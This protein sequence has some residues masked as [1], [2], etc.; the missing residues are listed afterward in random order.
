MS[1]YVG[2][3]FTNE[4]DIGKGASSTYGACIL[5]ICPNDIG[6]CTGN[7]CLQNNESCMWHACI[8]NNKK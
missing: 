6:S 5:N 3:V 7:F 2:N 8:N 4:N 1:Q